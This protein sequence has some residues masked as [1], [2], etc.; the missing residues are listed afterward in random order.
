MLRNPEYPGWGFMVKNGATTVW[1]RWELEMFNIMDS[2][3]HPMFGSY[4]AIFYRYLGGINLD[5]LYDNEITIHPRLAK[6]LDYV[7]CSFD[8]IKGRITS[9]WRRE[10]GIVEL[11]IVIPSNTKANLIFDYDSVEINGKVSPSHINVESGTYRIKIRE[12]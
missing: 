10:N 3:D 2:F 1:E 12:E 11:D 7:E 6:T 9:N 4:D 5:K 8:S